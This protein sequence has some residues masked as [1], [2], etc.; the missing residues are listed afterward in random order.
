MTGLLG[1]TTPY[2]SYLVF[3]AYIDQLAVQ[4]IFATTAAAIQDRVGSIHLLMQSVGGN[5]ADGI[6]LYN[7]FRALPVPLTIY[8]AGGVSSAAV[9]AYLG[10]PHRKTARSAAFMIHR[11]HATFQGANAEAIQARMQSLVMDDERTETILRQH[12]NLPKD[13]WAVHEHH[14]LWLTGEEA[15]QFGLATELGDFAPPKGATIYNV[16]SVPT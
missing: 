12:L 1:T 10:A 6:C 14:D 8:N 16:L 11:S 5:V 13:K 4:R 2:A 15:V 7:Y 9:L 3:A